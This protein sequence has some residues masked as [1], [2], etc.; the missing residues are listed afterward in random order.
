MFIKPDFGFSDTSKLAAFVFSKS[1]LWTTISWFPLE[2][3]DKKESSPDQILV[4]LHRYLRKGQHQVGQGDRGLS[5]K[6]FFP[7]AWANHSRPFCNWSFRELNRRPTTLQIGKITKSSPGM[8]H[9]KLWVCFFGWELE[10]T[11]ADAGN[12]APLHQPLYYPPKLGCHTLALQG[13]LRPHLLN[14]AVVL[15]TF[16]QEDK[17]LSAKQNN[18]TIQFSLTWLLS[19]S[20]VSVKG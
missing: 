10:G 14:R 17:F 11:G 7:T 20:S 3:L 19:F 15:F 16:H 8:T 5:K 13:T 4:S 18:G 2:G 6:S 1:P 9:C 12:T